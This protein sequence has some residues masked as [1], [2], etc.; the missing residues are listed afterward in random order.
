[1]GETLEYLYDQL[2]NS[3]PLCQQSETCYIHTG[4][5]HELPAIYVYCVYY[6]DVLRP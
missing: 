4:V 6:N 5:Y 2:F 3:K 1:M